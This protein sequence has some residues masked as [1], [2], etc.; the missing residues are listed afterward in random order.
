MGTDL[1]FAF[2]S[3][4]EHQLTR[5]ILERHHAQATSKLAGWRSSLPFLFNVCLVLHG[6]YK[7][8]ISTVLLLQ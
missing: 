7:V 1:L 3:T 2:L 8:I 5:A 4:A 6:F